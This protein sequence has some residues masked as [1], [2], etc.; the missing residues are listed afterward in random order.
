MKIVFS[1]LIFIL[2]GSQYAYSQ[3]PP[4]TPVVVSEIVVKEVRK[5]VN[6]VGTVEPIRTSLVSA[7]ING[8]VVEYLY[9]EGDYVEAGQ[10]IARQEKQR[11]KI[12]LE[13][14]INNQN[15]SSA[16]LNL[17]EDELKRFRELFEKG[18]VSKSQLDNAISKR[19]ALIARKKSLQ[20]SIDRLK[21]D[22]GRTDT[23]APF[24]GYITKEFSQ[25]GEWLDSGD[26]IIE[27][28]DID[29]VETVVELP[30]KYV[31][32]VNVGDEVEVTFNSLPGIT[33]KGELVSIVPKADESSRAFPVKVRLK[34]EDHVI[35]SSMSA[36]V[37]FLLGE[38]KETKMVLK[39]SII[40]NGGNKIIFVVRDNLAQPVPVLTGLAHEDLVEV[41]GEVK[42][43]E[44]VV[45]RGNERLR[46]M[47]PVEVTS[48]IN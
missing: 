32:L 29:N 35:K 11:L 18:I 14:A 47:Q 48:V 4:K 41:Q 8:I 45:V 42:V 2:T 46:P 31:H 15:E 24:N 25:I 38:T 5:P 19:D 44:Q 10:I 13:E 17:A 27:L 36:K 16:E 20:N 3:A 1:V 12:Q 7:S 9:S 26:N 28:I 21:Y 37:S 39:D 40:N 34:N 6:L 30:E 33:F 43:G 23:I 22:I